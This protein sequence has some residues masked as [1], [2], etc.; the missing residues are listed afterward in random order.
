MTGATLELADDDEPSTAITLSADPARVPEGGGAVAVVVTA[1]FD[2]SARNEPTEVSVSV[3]GSDSAEA[4]DFDPVGAFAITIEPG[5]LEGTGTFTLTPHDD[6]IDEADETLSVAGSSNLP[7]TGTTVALADDDETST[8]VLLSTSPER[9]AEG[10]GTAAVEVT[11]MLNAGARV[12]AT[13]VGVS[14]TGSGQSGLVGFQAVPDFEIEI[15]AAAKSGAGTF[16]VSPEDDEI[17]E[18][19]EV[20]T[21]A[22]TSDLRV[23]AA[24]ATL[25]DD[26]PT[27]SL[28]LL[29][30]DPSY[31][32]EDDGP[33]DVAVSATV[34]RSARRTATVVTVTVTD[35]GD[36]EAVAYEPV[37]DFPI[38]IPAGAKSGTE[39]FTLTP[40]ANSTVHVDEEL[41]LSGVSDLTVESFVVVLGDDD[42][43]SSRIRLFAVPSRVTEDAGPTEV[44]VTAQLNASALTEPT[45]VMVGVQESDAVE[46]VDFAPVPEFE[47]TVAANVVEGTG[48]FT[49][50]PDDDSLVETEE[51][52]TLSGNSDLPV[53]R[54][55]VALVDDDNASTR[56]LLT[57]APTRVSEGDGSTEVTV[58][59]SLDQDRRQA[60]TP[61]TVTVS[62]GGSANAVD[63]AAVADFEIV[64][65]ADAASAK[66]TF[67]LDPEDDH[68]DEVDGT[69]AVAG[70]ADLAAVPVEVV[71]T[72]DDEPPTR[73]LLSA[74]PARVSEGDGPKPVAVSASFDRGHREEATT[75]MLSVAGSG[76]PEVVDFNPVAEFR[77]TIPAHTTSATGTFTL[78]PRDDRNVEKD[79]VL[80]VSGTSGLPVTPTSLTLGDDDEV[81]TR[82][83]LILT[84]DPPQASEGGGPLSVSVNAGVDSGVRA[85]T[86][87]LWCPCRAAAI[88]TRWT[89]IPSPT[90]RSSSGRTPCPEKERSPWRR[91]TTKPWR[92]TKR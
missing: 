49:L 64:I 3:S 59:A 60:P 66:G 32:R 69:V 73:I 2:E 17:D 83:L 76:D 22:G 47:I 38:E 12:V 37:S 71:L 68:V 25:V 43:A 84:V 14:V 54:A 62:A 91:R 21:I 13:R 1:T 78:T 50:T 33:V 92:P 75:V 30:A 40:M 45:V 16:T 70:T 44:T 79:E 5:R 80:T 39:T 67:I 57:A 55:E 85:R 34:D 48:T 19:D 74:T 88:P 65:P 18:D 9:I 15:A 46:T 31:A 63:F 10:G 53:R 90:S 11:A 8:A 58:T 82:V 87:G 42:Q 4:V 26:D 20:L 86:P 6:P 77:I 51:T 29:Q 35:S 7:V 24:S 81:S 56:I 89:S 52:I 28:V 61:V 41:T 23:E 27:S 72:D 36:Q